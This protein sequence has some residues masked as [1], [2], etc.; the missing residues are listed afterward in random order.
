MINIDDGFGFLDK[1]PEI[2]Y[3]DSAATTLTHKSVLE[4][5]ELYTK[6][7]SVGL[8]RSSGKIGK[9][10]SDRIDGVRNKLCN[11]YNS[12]NL[13]FTFSSTDSL[14]TLALLLK[15]N[16]NIKKVALGIDNHHAALLPFYSFEKIFLDLDR[17]LN[18]DLSKVD[19]SIDLLVVTLCS[20]VL[21]NNLDYEKIRELKI[22][23]PKLI[24]V[25]DATQYF[26]FAKLDFTSLGVD[27]VIGSCHKMYGPLGLGFFLYKES[28]KGLLPSKVGGGIVENVSM[29]EV[30]YYSD[31]RQLEA[32]TLNVA[33]I[34]SLSKLLDFLEEFVY[35][36]DSLDFSELYNLE[37]YTFL[38]SKSSSKIVTFYHEKQSSFDLANF[39]A[40]KGLIVRSGSMC[41]MP[42]FDYLGCNEAV[43]VSFGV[44]NE[45][46]DIEQLVKTLKSF[47][48][49]E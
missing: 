9:I 11:F 21:G 36:T 25:V 46:N 43:R 30:K 40:L 38:N 37:E 17:D 19:D 2:I 42:L 15:Q 35:T 33:G 16:Y 39:L 13:A 10:L 49:L 28:Y 34:L 22:K 32:G 29:E 18:L 5:L 31:G 44:Y 26:S 7:L 23:Y 14:N 47:S 27:F 24:V 4:G 3:L 20:N 48:I 8:G 41:A 6:E 12:P 45:Q 1:N